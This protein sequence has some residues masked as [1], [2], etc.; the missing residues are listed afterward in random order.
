MV[1]LSFSNSRNYYYS[2]VNSIQSLGTISKFV[3]AFLETMMPCLETIWLSVALFALPMSNVKIVNEI[4]SASEVK[5]NPIT[6][7]MN[8][9]EIL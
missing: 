4:G 8:I 7:C 2:L 9:Y 5:N 6:I 3:Y 1:I